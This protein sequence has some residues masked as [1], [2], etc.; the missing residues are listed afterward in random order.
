MLSC[1]SGPGSRLGGLARVKQAWAWGTAG[2]R[3]CGS[4]VSAGST[5]LDSKPDSRPSSDSDL[6]WC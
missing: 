3:P 1:E 6:A 2:A 4:G 5:G